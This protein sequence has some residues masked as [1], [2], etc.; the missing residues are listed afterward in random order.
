M[1]TKI[2]LGANFPKPTVA[3]VNGY[4]LR[5]TSPP[6]TPQ[7][8]NYEVLNLANDAEATG[9]IT[10]DLPA[11]NFFLT[12]TIYTSVGGTSSVVGVMVGTIMFQ[13]ED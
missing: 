13:T 5:Q 10:T 9:T 6:G 1:A 8:L 11:N 2:P 4:R 3:S 7:V 12:P